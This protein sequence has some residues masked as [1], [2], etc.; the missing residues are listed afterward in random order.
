MK[1]FLVIPDP[2]NADQ[3]REKVNSL[4]TNI[5]QLQGTVGWVVA[6]PAKTTSTQIWDALTAGEERGEIVAF[7][8]SIETYRGYYDGGLWECLRT[9]RAENEST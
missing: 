2:N 3:V 1:C 4:F 8:M 7:V 5:Y 9:W 6:H